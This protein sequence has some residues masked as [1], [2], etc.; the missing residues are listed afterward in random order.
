L[1]LEVCP[2]FE[3]LVWVL[4]L[5]LL[6]LVVEAVVAVVEFAVFEDLL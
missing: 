4:G 5:E 1:I 3:D 6:E 2:V